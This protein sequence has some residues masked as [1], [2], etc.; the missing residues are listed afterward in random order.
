MTESEISTPSWFSAHPVEGRKSAVLEHV[1]FHSLQSLL[2]EVSQDDEE[3]LQKESMGSNR[4]AGRMTATMKHAREEEEPV[5]ETGTTQQQARD[6]PKERIQVLSQSSKSPNVRKKLKK[7]EKMAIALL[8]ELESPPTSKS[9]HHEGPCLPTSALRFSKY[10]VFL[11]QRKAGCVLSYEWRYGFILYQSAPRVW[12]EPVFL[13]HRYVSVGA[14]CGWSCGGSVF[15]ISNDAA[16]IEFMKHTPLTRLP[17]TVSVD[18]RFSN[19]SVNNSITCK[20]VG[21]HVTRYHIDS[22]MSYIVDLSFKIGR[23]SV[24]KDMHDAVYGSPTVSARDILD[25]HVSQ[26]CQSDMSRLYQHLGAKSRNLAAIARETKHLFE[27]ERKSLYTSMSAVQRQSSSCLSKGR[28]SQTSSISAPDSAGL[29]DAS[30]Q[31][32]VMA[33]QSSLFADSQL[34]DLDLGDP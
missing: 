17:N 32:S 24:D 27:E 21:N 31:S 28:L 29:H 19:D 10:I 25:G 4:D 22:A 6:V 15:A 3:I 18:C 13:K 23:E 16:M 20:S 12:S 2:S 11:W 30:N 34:L 33:K 9:V 5:P 7:M 8:E 1:R 14:T 26:S